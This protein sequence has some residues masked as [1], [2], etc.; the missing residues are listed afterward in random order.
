MVNTKNFSADE[1]TCG[2]GCGLNNME[3]CFIEILQRIRDKVAHKMIVT[4]G[5]RCKVQNQAVGG[6][7]NSA[8]TKGWAADIVCTTDKFRLKLV[9]AALDE[10]VRRIGIYYTFIHLDMDMT[11][12]SGV[13][14]LKK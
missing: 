13:M 9:K 8:H 6:K 12:P 5:S 14:W 10:G 4:S 1:F 11:L 7:P 3:Q 2:C